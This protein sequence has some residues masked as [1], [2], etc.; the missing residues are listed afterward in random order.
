MAK[1][2]TKLYSRPGAEAYHV[3][4]D[5]NGQVQVK[6]G[7]RTA[8]TAVPSGPGLGKL[9]VG[10]RDALIVGAANVIVPADFDPAPFRKMFA[11]AA[12]GLGRLMV[13]GDSTT[14]GDGAGTGTTVK[15]TGARPKSYPV[16]LAQY[17]S[18]FGIPAYARSLC[19]WGMG[20]SGVAP[21]AYDPDLT[22]SG[23]T[24]EALQNFG[25]HAYRSVAAGST[26]TRVIP[27]WSDGA[28][29]VF[30]SY[31]GY[32]SVDISINGGATIQTV[33]TAAT[34]RQATRTTV[35]WP[36][37]Q[38]VSITFTTTS[39][40]PVSVQG[41]IPMDTLAGGL[42]IVPAGW[43]GSKI[44]DHCYDQ[45]DWQGFRSLA[46]YAV[47]AAV[48]QLT[49]N[50]SNAGTTLAAYAASLDYISA[51][52]AAANVPLIWM[53]GIDSNN[54]AAANDLELGYIE[55]IKA[56]A[57]ADKSLFIDLR[58]QMGSYAEMSARGWMADNNH[59]N[60]LSYADEARFLARVI[61]ALA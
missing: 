15:L 51:K 41:F 43:W 45:Y 20:S 6:M 55:L 31:S 11:R 22:Y 49:I 10:G 2:L 26:L 50:D 19:G 1:D 40:S 54:S 24:A 33:A 36:R 46:S 5:D 17:L 44:A 39:T 16:R 7:N 58:S 27:G 32:G 48:V 35:T 12:S 59:G 56:R 38:N 52:A 25:G 13:I 8:V 37:A 28:D 53:S 57:A 30:N 34:P 23:F 60:G 9:S 3:F 21:S 14:L 47:D 29:L 18:A 61:A 4:E 42:E